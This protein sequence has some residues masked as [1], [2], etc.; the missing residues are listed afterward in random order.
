MSGVPNLYWEAFWM[1]NSSAE[2]RMIFYLSFIVVIFTGQKFCK[3]RKVWNL[4]KN[5]H[6]KKNWNSSVVV[7]VLATDYPLYRSTKWPRWKQE[8]ASPSCNLADEPKS[9]AVGD[10]LLGP[11]DSFQNSWQGSDFVPPTIV[12]KLPWIAFETF[13]HTTFP[14]RMDFSSKKKNGNIEK[15]RR[16][17]IFVIGVGTDRKHSHNWFPIVLY[18]DCGM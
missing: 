6:F 11:H 1:T 14:P 12:V 15:S 5:W 4:L 2:P 9:I 16:L 17:R 3:P 13:A 18:C 10:V 8:L 7:R